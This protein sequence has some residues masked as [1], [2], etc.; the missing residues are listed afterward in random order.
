MDSKGLYV[1]PFSGGQWRFEEESP[2]PPPTRGIQA[3]R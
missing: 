1:I 3:R 2:D